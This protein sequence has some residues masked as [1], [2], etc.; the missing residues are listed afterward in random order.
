M[1]KQFPFYKQLDEMDCGATCLRMIAA[2]HGRRYSLEFLRERTFQ[3]REGVS[4]LAI[5]AASEEIGMHS[6]AVK[7]SYERMIDD[8]PMPLIAHWNQEHFIVVY[9]ANKRHVWVADPSK[10]KFKITREQFEQSWASD[11]V[12]GQPVGVLLLLEATPDF[13]TAEGEQLDKGGFGYLLS[14]LRNYKG[15]VFQ[16]VLGLLVGSLLQLA[17]PFL[18]QSIVDVGINDLNISFIYLVLLAQL[19]L[20]I[21]SLSVEFI[22][23]WILLHIG[24]RINI[25]LVSDFL[26]KL[27][28]LP[29]RFFE[30]KMLGDL[31]Q[32]IYDNE[33]V[34]Q[35]LTSSLLITAFSFFNFFIFGFVLWY[36]SVPIFLIF[37]GFTAVYILYVTIFLR[38]RRKLDYERFMESSANQGSL[39]Q[40]IRG[41]QEIK[42]HNAEKQKRWE[43]ERIQARLFRVSIK[44]LKVEQYQRIGAGFINEVKNI[45]VIVVAATAV[46]EGRMSLGQMLAIQYII[47]QLNAPLKQLINFV[48]QAQDAKISLERMNEIHQKENEEN[49]ADKIVD[50]PEYGGLSFEDVS[51]SYGGPAS[52]MVLKKLNLY[53]PKGKTTAIVGTSGSGKTT[54]LKLLLKFYRPTEGKVRLGDL[55]LDNIGSQW[56][57]SKVGTVMQDG[58]IFNDTIARNIA[59]GHDTVDKVRL[60]KAVKLAEIQNHIESLPLGYN[61]KIGQDGIGLSRGQTQRLL[62]A[63]AVYKNP[64]YLFFDEATN[65]LDA[66]N[67]MLVMENL[68]EWFADKTVVTV[69]HRL[70]TVMNADNIVVLEHGEI[71][72]QGTHTELTRIRGAYFQLVKNQLELGD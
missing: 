1:A 22:R 53:I 54:I 55:N 20:F 3:S 68:E 61:T 8:L 36:F 2:Y 50:L 59:L 42:L 26:M 27:M 9:K 31:L 70:S 69:A 40:L 23:S 44:Y 14:Y 10:G 45:L 29:I 43:W 18:M 51:F 13:F 16:L 58:Y 25:S 37:F 35:L 67:E 24:V 66:Y 5:S 62:I 71:I 19:V 7:I 46:I 52:P 47:G 28:K 12:N 64:E 72:E 21:S 17:F 56:W 6:L 15:L 65:S 39:I 32:R 41:M 11:V 60:L 57:R 38:V 48:Q 63:R 33:R 49:I 34:E 4:M 30:S